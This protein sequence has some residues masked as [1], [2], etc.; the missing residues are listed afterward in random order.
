M[1]DADT[2][3]FHRPRALDEALFFLE[4]ACRSRRK[5]RRLLACRLLACRLLA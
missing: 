1:G 2:A 4:R 5:M 3:D